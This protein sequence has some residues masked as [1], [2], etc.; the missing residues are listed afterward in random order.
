MFKK[1][2]SN[3]FSINL[4]EEP[5][6]L[7]IFF[8]TSLVIFIVS[9][10]VSLTDLAH[11]NGGDFN[12]RYIQAKCGFTEMEPYTTTASWW[13]NGIPRDIHE[14]FF[15]GV[16]RP[17]GVA[18]QTPALLLLYMPLSLLN[19]ETARW[20]S[21]ILEWVA[22]FM[23]VILLGRI[24][25]RNTDRILAVST[26]FFFFAGSPFWRLH[27]ER[28]Q[29]YIF[30]VLLLILF[31]LVLVR[32]KNDFVA[33][34]I[35][36]FTIIVRPTVIFLTLPFFLQKRWKLLAGSICSAFLVASLSICVFG[37]ESWQNF[38][39][40]SKKYEAASIDFSANPFKDCMKY[41]KVPP[42]EDYEITGKVKGASF[43]SVN[44]TVAG[45]IRVT[46]PILDRY[47]ISTDFLLLASKLLGIGL[48][49]GFIFLFIFTKIP[50]FRNM[51]HPP[52]T[53]LFFT[54]IV[55]I[56]LLE[57]AIPYRAAY[58]DICY[59]IPVMLGIPMLVESKKPWIGIV[60]LISLSSQQNMLSLVN[61]WYSIPIRIIGLSVFS[62]AL[63]YYW[64]RQI[65][66]P[67]RVDD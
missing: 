23:S 28:G 55:A 26:A 12:L 2:F 5:V 61:G 4:S 45:M 49:T 1:L 15:K 27:V 51:P 9:L 25:N 63:L 13:W 16:P 33:G 40:M 66:I 6:W 59:L 38:H 48:A 17:W 39:F 57:Y 67:N 20:C 18:C 65:N 8:H 24:I 60:L 19:W 34:L 54:G 10:I 47:R 43:P 46:K 52:D 14:T 32:K 41:E 58:A 44:S 35:L 11:Y 53:Y 31:L 30:V 21:G 29:Y 64:R 42:L 36:G 62:I 56:N 50:F 7:R 22:F 3:I 37:V